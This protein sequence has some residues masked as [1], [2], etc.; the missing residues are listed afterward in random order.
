MKIL[1]KTEGI[2]GYLIY[3]AVPVFVIAIWAAFFLN[4]DLE[5]EV[6]PDFFFSSDSSIYKKNQAIREVFPSNQ[7]I[8]LN[9]GTAGSIEDP[10]F[11]TKIGSLTTRI[12]ALK[13][14]TSVQSITNGP[15]DLDAARKNPLW[16][17][18]L[19]GKDEKSS[20][21]IA[22][23]NTDNFAGLVEKVEQIASEEESQRYS[24][25]ISGLPYIV[26][27]I[28]RNLTNDMK[29]FT[30]GAV[31]LS[32]LVLSVI[33]R[34]ATV[35][36]G[37][38]V[39]C[40]TAAVLTLTLQSFM[41]I[42]IG[43]LTANLGTIVFV[44][45]LSHI[46]FLVSNW[47]NSENKVAGAKL[48]E[49]IRHTLPA[50][51]W[52]GTTTLLGFSSLIFVEAKPL[53][54]LGIGGTIGT[55]CAFVCAYTIFPA[56]LR[57]AQVNP[58]SFSYMLA[59]KFPRAR[60]IT[61][62]L[63]VITI[64]AALGLGITGISKLNTDP[65][66]LSYFKEDSKIYKG[67][68]YV[69]DNGGS[70]PLLLV[71]RR[72]DLGK[73]DK[74]DSYD[75]MWELQQALSEHASVGSVIS[76]PVIMAEG[77]EHWL[78]KLLPWNILLDILSKPE[79]GAVANSFVNKERT[80]ALFMLRMIEAGRDR[81]RL[82]IINEIEKIPAQHG[83]AVTLTGGTYYLQGE[84]A[85]SVTKSMTMGI[86][87]LILL[88][89]V[90]AF[91]ISSSLMVTV[92]VMV[93]AASISAIVLGT[94]GIAGIPIDIISSPAMNICLGLIVDNM[95][96]LTVT[97]RR[98][99]KERGATSIRDWE[100]WKNALDSQSWPALVSTITIMIGFS[101]FALSDFPPSQRFGLEITYGAGLAVILSLG[102]FPHIVARVA[103]P[104]TKGQQTP[105]H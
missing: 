66:L 62:V 68:F 2:S 23:I 42:P 67:I 78:G 99:M 104:N 79:Y 92:G 80:H 100:I 52:A 89:G 76:L 30:L 96:H 5:P 19:I 63:L 102:V 77:D 57:M 15:D 37:A 90:I 26:E 41:G 14:V 17:R 55:A 25:H 11:I 44:L 43:I 38:V 60:H 6:T 56:F 97:A 33:F 32:A 24:I 74:G 64:G 86:L 71:I 21:V 65:S 8:L 35:V 36:S 83:F 4:V 88:F 91:I 81:D 103:P 12:K 46:I 51:F 73:L 94:L 28:R 82:E 1:P 101:V 58:S 105:S 34:S 20:F 3:I 93:C 10:N 49:T 69:D 85:A 45:T 40:V 98:Q 59:R 13:G 39:T 87:T 54:Q 22:F 53:N 95:I 7:Q 75:R 9:V 61:R 29:V 84:L 27:Q 47:C 70:N 31:I 16:K 72:N 48:Q 18:L 50:S